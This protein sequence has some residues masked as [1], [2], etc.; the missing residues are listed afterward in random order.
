VKLLKHDAPLISERALHRELLL[1][2]RDPRPQVCGL[3]GV[4]LRSRAYAPTLSGGGLDRCDGYAPLIAYG[5]RGEI[6]ALS[7]ARLYAPAPC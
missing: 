1:K 7:L 6:R 4:T 5:R 2:L 3:N